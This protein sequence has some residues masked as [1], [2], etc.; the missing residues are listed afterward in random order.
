MS[1]IYY[2]AYGSNLNVEQMK[3]RCPNAVPFIT[4]NIWGYRLIFRGVADIIKSHRHD[5][6][7]TML[8]HITPECEAALDRYEGFPH[9]YR[10]QYWNYPYAKE[11]K[12]MAYVMNRGEIRPPSQTYYNSIVDGYFDHGLCTRSLSAARRESEQTFLDN[13]GGLSKGLFYGS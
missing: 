1:K 9:L 5:Y 12:V 3:L 7:Q 10:K 6:V 13:N 8:W 4:Y 2:A 11:W